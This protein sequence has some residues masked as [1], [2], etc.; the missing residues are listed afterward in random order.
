MGCFD[1]ICIK[2]GKKCLT[3]NGG[4]NL[5]DDGKCYVTNKECKLLLE[6]WYSGY[7][8]AE[9]REESIYDLSMNDFFD[10]W[11]V[12]PEDKRAYFVCQNCAKRMKKCN[13]FNELYKEKSTT[14]PVCLEGK[15]TSL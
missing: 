8:Y 1:Y 14:G 13:D 5:V 7:G 12:K 4:Q 6:V 2:K 10:C 9:W 15:G 3:P 11:D